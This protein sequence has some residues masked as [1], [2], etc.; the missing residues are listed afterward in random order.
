M[1]DNKRSI[2]ESLVVLEC[3]NRLLEKGY[4][5]QNI[6]LEIPFKAGT[7]EKG[8]WLDIMLKKDDVAFALIECKTFGKE[9][10]Q[11]RQKMNKHGGQLFSYFA[12]QTDA[13][14]LILYST[15][16]ETP[17][18]NECDIIKT[19]IFK[20][21]TNNAERM[22]VWD[23][24][25]ES[26]GFFESE[27]LYDFNA[28]L[29]KKNLMPI[30]YDDIYSTV[31][32]SN[33]VNGTIFNRFAEILRR[34]T[35]SDKT[36]S[37]N[38]IFNLFLCKIIDEDSSSEDKILD[39]Q[40]KNNE[41]AEEVISRLSTL[42][43]KGMQKYMELDVT[44]HT[45]KEFEEQLKNLSDKQEAVKMF[46]E[47][48]L[49]KNNEFAFKEVINKRT[50]DENAKVVKEVVKLLEKYQIKYSCKQAF[51]G[52]FFER[53]LNI[54]IKQEAGQFFTPVPIARFI[55]N[56][57][58][59]EKVI[60]QKIND[61]EKDFLPRII[62]YACGS[63]HFLTEG[64][65]RLQNIIDEKINTTNLTQGQKSNISFWQTNKETN[66]AYNWAKDY[67]YGIE[68]DYRLVKT[69]KI[70]CFLNGDGEA[71]IIYGDGLES[72]GSEYYRGVLK[73]KHNKENKQ[74]DV[75]IANPPFSV[76]CFKE[77]LENGAKDFELFNALGDR[78]DDIECLFIERTAQ[79][80]KDDG[81]CA[82]ILPSTILTNGGIHSK[83][84]RLF[85]EN[86]ELR[87]IQK[88]HGGVFAA[89]PNTTLVLFGVRRKSRDITLKNIDKLLQEYLS[90]KL[91]INY[92]QN[93]NVISKYCSIIETTFEDFTAKI[94]TD[95]SFKKDQLQRLK[96]FLLTNAQP[97]LIGDYD[98]KSEKGK[99]EKIF[100]GYEHSG[101]Q[102]YE[103]IHPFPKNAEGKINSKLY[104]DN[105]PLDG[106]KVSSYIYKILS[107]EK[108]D[109]S[110]IDTSLHKN[111]HITTLEKLV[112]WDEREFSLY[113]NVDKIQDTAIWKYK[114]ERLDT[115]YDELLN[116][117][118]EPISENDRYNIVGE[119]PYCGATGII[120]YI[121]KFN[122]EDECLLIAEDGGNWSKNSPTSYIMSGKYWVNNHAHVLLFKNKTTQKF[123]HYAL[124]FLDLNQYVTPSA[125]RKLNQSNLKSIKIPFPPLE[126]QQQII[127]EISQIEQNGQKV[128]RD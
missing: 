70:A 116:N 64:M 43:K 52:D 106:K 21:C 86:F 14:Y 98:A 121:N 65:D 37:Y 62:D 73:E 8:Q 102:K 99:L 38:K 10:R 110:N 12:N 18:K 75:V 22:K 126:I 87:A 45:E 95:E 49:Y 81:I 127:D 93:Q 35:V 4:L 6:S 79:L 115:L 33:D 108:I 31:K 58:P 3:V 113:V 25:T 30:S 72:F 26:N 15:S 109:N 60:N 39:F 89:T 47:I 120:G 123:I 96:F 51:L 1:Q 111:I 104:T 100:L 36:N 27:L 128:E 76:E 54:G 124:D 50:F 94:T 63:G 56:S 11:E 69:T 97:C 118:R 9:H 90:T 71:N 48:R 125:P 84:R 103:G 114:L 66:V 40:W 5:P 91:D 41:T 83:A 112:N 42:Y 117:K 57:I 67:V 78:S 101:R 53:L 34:H 17:D 13:K 77:T 92:N 46:Q 107:D 105:N 119:Y 23:R 29:R 44:D 82:I 88:L 2:D 122:F 20:D 85:I 55:V 80:L 16:I 74:F 61:G 24:T 7:Q 28:G 59:F 68:K 19:D 32:N